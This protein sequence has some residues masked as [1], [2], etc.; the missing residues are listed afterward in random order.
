MGKKK[1]AVLAAVKESGGTYV[2]LGHGKSCTDVGYVHSVAALNS[3]IAGYAAKHGITRVYVMTGHNI[4]SCG[5]GPCAY[6]SVK[7][8]IK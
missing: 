1:D 5:D 3:R 2:S 6:F 7:V 4:M 8:E